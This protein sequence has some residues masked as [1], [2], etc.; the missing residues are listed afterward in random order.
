MG[1]PSITPNLP[2]NYLYSR[3]IVVLIYM[4]I[5]MYIYLV[6]RGGQW[7]GGTS[8][9]IRKSAFFCRED[10][11][12]HGQSHQLHN[13]ACA[14]AGPGL[15]LRP[16]SPQDKQLQTVCCRQPLSMCISSPCICTVQCI[17]ASSVRCALTCDVCMCT[18][19]VSTYNEF[20]Y[21]VHYL[22]SDNASRLRT[23]ISFQSAVTP[24]VR[25]VDV[26]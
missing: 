7:I 14:Q 16:Q 25:T 13:L 23:S 4:H 5:L 12:R 11:C 17:Y 10:S 8:K 9:T 2:S 6:F 15:V 18:K 24:H 3:G 1:G 20:L 19:Y 21:N 26:P 22:Y